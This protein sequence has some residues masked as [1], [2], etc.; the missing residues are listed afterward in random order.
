M[1]FILW[2]EKEDAPE[3]GEEPLD[4]VADDEGHAGEPDVPWG[5]GHMRQAAAVAVGVVPLEGQ[6]C[7]GFFVIPD[8]AV[9]GTAAGGVYDTVDRPAGGL[10]GALHGGEVGIGTHVVG[11]EEEVGHA[12]A[13][14]GGGSMSGRY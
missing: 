10:V 1:L 14:L 2:F 7:P 13:G 11:S 12:G 8:A 3:G 6:E 5:P 9:A 4:A